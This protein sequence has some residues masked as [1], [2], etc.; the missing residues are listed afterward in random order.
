MYL[1]ASC[2]D[3]AEALR[4]KGILLRACRNFRGLGPGW[5]R[6]AIRTAEENDALLRALKEGHNG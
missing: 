4:E 3:L 6:T 1:P 5:Y 2:P